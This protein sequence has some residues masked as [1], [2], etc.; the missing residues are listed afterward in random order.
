MGKGRRHLGIARAVACAVVLLGLA[1]PPLATSQ[2]ERRGICGTQVLRDYTGFLENLTP[3]A[4]VPIPERL[5]FAPERVFFGALGR[6]ALQAGWGIRGFRLSYSPNQPEPPPELNWN[7]TS[8]LTPIDRYGQPLA[9]M[10]VIQQ[11]VDRLQPVGPEGAGEVRWSYYVPGQPAIYRLEI[12]FENELGEPLGAFGEYFR[13]MKPSVDY[14]FSLNKKKF[15]PGQTVRAKLSN[16]GVA[17]L[18]FGLGKTVEY[19]DGTSWTE[20]PVEFG[21]GLVPAILLGAGPGTSKACWSVTIP[22]NAPPGRYRLATS[23]EVWKRLVPA[24]PRDRR[25]VRA[26]FTVLPHPLVP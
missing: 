4:S 7:V 14:R 26:G 17:A 18:A 11:H 22:E 1:F 24:F 25:R 5:P 21:G 19:H 13:V 3:L 15:R 16:Y 8:T 23:I 6:G 12:V 2:A 9:P 10:Q 20:P